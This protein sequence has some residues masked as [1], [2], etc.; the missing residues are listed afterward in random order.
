MKVDNYEATIGID[1]AFNE[2]WNLLFDGGAR[3]T[4]FETRF[5]VLELVQ[6]FPPLPLF[7]LV[8]VEKTERNRGWGV[9]GQ[10]ALTYKGERD[11]GNLS[12]DPRHISGQRAL[13]ID[14]EDLFCFLCEQEVY[15]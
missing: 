12:A 1:R 9:V 10:L 11:N 15:L 3:Y 5:T 4:D 6:P 7:N 8:P 13:G 14:R 2:K